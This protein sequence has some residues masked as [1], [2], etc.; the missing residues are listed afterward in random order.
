MRGSM[1]VLL[2][3]AGIVGAVVLLLHLFV[4]DSW[5]VPHGE[6]KAF[7]TSLLPALMA[8]DQVL[9]RRGAVPRY[10]EL[11]RCRHPTDS[12]RWVVG[13]VF[14]EHGDKVEVNDRGVS[15][16]GKMIAASHGCGERMVAHPVTND[17]VTMQCGSA[18][19][20]AW[21]F[22]YLTAERGTSIGTHH[23]V[24]EA[25]KLFLVSDN[26]LM[27]EDSR[28]FGLVDASTC[29]HIVYRLWGEHF[30]DGSR[31]FTILW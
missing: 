19:T 31:R 27:H 21:S 2:W 13:R 11:A 9:V 1:R 26:R 23:A 22:E 14:G 16:N 18:E 7:E 15:T 25:G 8:D 17:L 5:V 10:A 30:T 4:F 3:L 24:V 6:D 20:G 12:S 29:E 28:D